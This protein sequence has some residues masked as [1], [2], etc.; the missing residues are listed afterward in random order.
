VEA[1]RNCFGSH[2]GLRKK[3][4]DVR[5]FQGRYDSIIHHTEV[6]PQYP[7]LLQQTFNGHVVPG[8]AAPRPQSDLASQWDEH[9]FSQ[10]SRS[11][12]HYHCQ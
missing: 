5:L 11:R 12:P 9:P 7:D 8:I 3:A 4:G 1:V 10:C 6:V 2:I